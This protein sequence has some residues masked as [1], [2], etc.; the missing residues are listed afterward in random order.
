MI[1]SL[2][3]SSGNRMWKRR[4]GISAPARDR[5]D[6]GHFIARLQRRVLA[7]QEADVLFIHIDIDEAPQLALVV[8]EPLFQ[9]R[10]RAVEVLDD[11]GNCRAFLFDFALSLGERA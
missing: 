9:S 2:I 3:F 5:R 8:A 1:G 4:L 7:L 11:F 6:D 10:I